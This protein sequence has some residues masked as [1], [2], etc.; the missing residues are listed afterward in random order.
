MSHSKTEKG[1]G[2]GRSDASDA[3]QMLMN[4]KKPKSS[5]SSRPKFQFVSCPLCC[6]KR[7]LDSEVSDHMDKCTKRIKQSDD[8]RRTS[9]DLKLPARTH[10]DGISEKLV[11]TSPTQNFSP[12]NAPIVSTT[13]SSQTPFPDHCLSEEISSEENPD[14]SGYNAKNVFAHIMDQS[15]IHFAEKKIPRVRLH[16]DNDF[17][18]HLL[19][20]DPSQVHMV[21]Q[22]WSESVK[23]RQR[24][25]EEESSTGNSSTPTDIETVLSSSYIAPKEPTPRFVKRHSR[26]SVP[27]LKSILQKSIRR[28]KPL[29]SVRVAMELADKSVGELLRRL[30]IIIL[31]DSMLH[32]ELDFLVWLMVAYTKDFV[33]TKSLLAK[34][35][36]IVYE[37]AMCNWKDVPPPGHSKIA[38]H[39]PFDKILSDS[40][41]P[42]KARGLLWAIG[43]RS[44]YGGMLGDIQMLNSLCTVWY[45]RFSADKIYDIDS[46]VMNISDKTR[47]ASNDCKLIDTV[48]QCHRQ[49]IE[50]SSKID[51]MSEEGFEFLR[52]QD[53]CLEGVDF[54]CSRVIDD[55]LSDRN[56]VHLSIDL[57][58]FSEDKRRP[59]ASQRISRTDQQTELVEVLKKCMWKYAS[60][61]NYRQS[62]CSS[63]VCTKNENQENYD[64]FWKELVHP[65]VRKY[66]TRYLS[67]RLV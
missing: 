24:Y 65:W 56:L 52:L 42:R 39:V 16:L 47:N 10:T 49:G 43:A 31:E 23:L 35:F 45:H 34:V 46:K 40:D 66:Q 8:A 17:R 28:R 32:P 26:L 50:T 60:G 21:S 36:K 2:R 20:D 19:D 44:S 59:T 11:N 53:C 29:P 12:A 41:I 1:H 38:L 18:V 55:F 62:L 3:F 58:S 48:E 7:L 25:R 64:A 30:P 4:R 51:T 54:H 37:C 57:L 67:E 22:K 9:M 14:H 33:P 5:F 15:R 27:V 13:P 61:V 63:E 6:G